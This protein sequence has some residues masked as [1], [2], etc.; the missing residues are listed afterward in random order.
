MSLTEADVHA[1]RRVLGR[2]PTRTPYD[3]E[4][5]YSPVAGATGGVWRVRMAD[6]ALVL[7]V[8]RPGDDGSPRWRASS[9]EANGYYWRREARALA[10]GPLTEAFA[11][12]PDGL[13]PVRCHAVVERADGSIALWL[14]DLTGAPAAG[15]PF[16]RYHRA[17]RQL[18]HAQARLASS[19]LLD[20]PWLSQT[21]LREYAARHH[22]AGD[23][24]DDPTLWYS[25]LARAVFTRPQPLETAAL[26]RGVPARLDELDALPQT[27]THFDFHPG[28]LFDAAGDTVVLDWAYAGRGPVGLDAAALVLE[29]VF[30]YH[31]PG[32]RIGELFDLVA[33]GYAA[34]HAAAGGPL[35]A[36]GVRRSMALAATTKLA[37][38]LPELLGLLRDEGETCNGRPL[39]EGAP[40]WAAATELLLDLLAE[41]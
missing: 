19:T 14:E 1:I 23:V 7:K 29:A 31:V 17:A 35:D 25:P 39:R 24:L 37:W 27:L 33:A 9:D 4:Q 28:N 40:A 12:T 10:Q 20:A 26:W 41:L 3:A 30:D 38:T 6:G 21:W 15:W 32:E 8:L 34:G 18:G 11:G 22:D 5:L 13:R 36:A 16:E 2:A